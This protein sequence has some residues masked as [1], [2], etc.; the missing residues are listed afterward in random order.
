MTCSEF[1]TRFS[2]FYDEPAGSDIRRRAARHMES[3]S[4][5]RRY[6]EVVERG[7]RMLR[8]MPAAQISPSFG[9]RL[10]HRIHHVL[11]EEANRRDGIASAM[12]V[13]TLV[14]MAV[15]LTVVA[16]APKL[17]DTTP[18]VELPPI[19]ISNPPSDAMPVR[20]GP[21][22]FLTGQPGSLLRVG[23]GLWDDPNSLLYEYSP[24]SGKYRTNRVLTRTGLD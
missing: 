4:A 22:R 7:V 17:R 24:L 13:V 18:E 1:L 16:W 2:D 9:S 5:C 8:S 11:D 23:D 12:P 15:L 20:V 3:C 6:F 14:G 10:E 21:S 19:V